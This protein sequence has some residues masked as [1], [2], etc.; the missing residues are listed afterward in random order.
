MSACVPASATNQRISGFCRSSSSSEACQ[1]ILLADC[2]VAGYRAGSQGG[3]LRAAAWTASWI[4]AWRS[5]SGGVLVPG[6]GKATDADQA[7]QQLTACT[8][9]EF[10][11]LVPQ[12]KMSASFEASL[13]ARASAS[14][15]TGTGATGGIG[16]RFWQARSRSSRAPGP[17]PQPRDHHQGAGMQGWP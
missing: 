5:G 17:G 4:L 15:T 10:R 6:R 13:R 14:R 1:A 7:R 3:S 9:S 8:G 2:P 11:D 16:G 12:Y